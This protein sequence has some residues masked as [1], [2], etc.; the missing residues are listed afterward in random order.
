MADFNILSPSQQVADHLRSKLLLGQWSGTMPGSPSLAA[1]LGVDSKTIWAALTILEQEGILF[2]QGPGRPRKIVMP[3]TSKNAASL[4]IAILEYEVASLN[5]DYMV[6]LRHKLTGSGHRVIQSAKTLTE[7]QMKVPRIQSMVKETDADAW[8]VCAAARNVLQWFS[9]Q[10]T[11]VFAL[12]GRRRKFAIAGVGPDHEAVGRLIVQRLVE[13]GHQR[14]VILARESQRA[15]GP[16]RS[17]QAVF[18]EMANHGLSIGSY[19]LPEWE[20]SAD[21]LQR[22]LDGLFKVTPP[23]ALIVDEPFVFHA[24]KDHLARRGIIA[25]EDVS[26]I[27]RDPDQTFDWLRP[28]VAHVRWDHRPIV[29]R[30]VN[31]AANISQGKVDRRQTLTKA[32]FIEGGTVGLAP[33]QRQ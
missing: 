10:E 5:D 7:L 20:N 19:N 32:E 12:F 18:D 24:V 14:I 28:S 11:P 9:N 4:R 23:T 22:V 13:L 29:R 33:S 27:C 8:I 15:G 3:S 16:G 25:P 21:G 17:D 1:E 2:G 30:I 31:W 26:L 6:D